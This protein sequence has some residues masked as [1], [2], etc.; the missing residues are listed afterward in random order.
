[1]KKCNTE[2][3]KDLKEIQELI[4]HHRF[5]TI[6]SS[7]I[8]YT[9]EDRNDIES[10]FN[11]EKSLDELEYLQKEERKIKNILAYSNATT[12]VDGYDFTIAEGLV[13]LAQLSSNKAQL[14]RL[15]TAEPLKRESNYRGYI[16]YTRA[17]YDISKAQNDLAKIN[18][19]IAQLQMA[20]D[21]T[22]LTNMIDVE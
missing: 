21:R 5:D 1:M 12:K 3:M 11:Y 9:S 22:N 8:V 13:Y 17:N 7:F 6:R 18:R 2:L 16:E 14:T 19:Q 4:S 20:I 10:D 15:A